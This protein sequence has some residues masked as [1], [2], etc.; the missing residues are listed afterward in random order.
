M[1][2]PLTLRT[3]IAPYPHVLALRDGTVSSPRIRFNF[4]EVEPITR[5]FRR[6]VRS[7]EFDL[8]EMAVTT[9]AQA[10]ACG[11]PVTG[12]SAVLMRGFHHNALVCPA[13]SSLVGPSG[14]HGRRIGVRA[15]SQT[16]GVWVRGLLQHE[17]RVDP[18]A[19]TWVT[20]ED[21][22]VAEYIDPPLVERAEA[23]LNSLFRR[24][25]IDAAVALRGLGPG[26]SR[27]VIPEA[28]REAARWYAATGIYPV[29]HALVMRRPLLA[30]YPWLAQELMAL[31]TAARD[32]ARPEPHPIAG[33]ALPYGLDA[34]RRSI[35][36]LAGYAA[37]QGLTPRCYAAEELFAA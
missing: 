14:L 25:G 13:G 1:A 12:L 22:H 30:D 17:Y 19:M 18:M 7:L 32:A 34:N 27:T 23:P 6:M 11:K 10:I 24:G 8:C 21:A 36:V 20:E 31:F 35:E 3:A 2:E 26:E 4:V 5:A 15:W 9:L 37:G 16:T 29:N 33:E 28:D